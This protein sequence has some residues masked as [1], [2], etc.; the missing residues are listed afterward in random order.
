MKDMIKYEEFEKKSEKTDDIIALTKVEGEYQKI[1][2]PIEI[3]KIIDIITEPEELKKLE[4][5]MPGA[6]FHMDTELKEVK[7]GD[8]IY[9]TCILKRPHSSISYNATALHGILKCRV[10]DIYSGLSKLKDIIK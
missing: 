7:R 1:K 6:L 5:A 8:T 2:G 3:E 10:V 4:S 9:V